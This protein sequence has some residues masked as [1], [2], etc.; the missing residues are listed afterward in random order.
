MDRIDREA[1]FTDA[2]DADRSTI[3]CLLNYKTLSLRAEGILSFADII[4]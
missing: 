4:H 2:A 1:I 3:P